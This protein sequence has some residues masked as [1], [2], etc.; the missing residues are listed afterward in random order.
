MEKTGTEILINE[1]IYHQYLMNNGTIL[2]RFQELNP[3]EYIALHTVARIASEEDIYLG[4]TYLKDLADKMQLSIRHTS[5]IVG[6]LR[7]K[8]LV[9]WAHDGNGN[10][11]TYVEI[12][13]TGEE[14]LNSQDSQLRAYYER[15]IDKFGR[16]NL[17]SLLQLMKQLETVMSSELE[18][19]DKLC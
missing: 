6:K 4:K 5:E 15:V 3:A 9:T 14:L 8:G 1:L 10:D 7:D 17:I 12:T 16:E 11:G 19:E 2:R 18:Q 13:P